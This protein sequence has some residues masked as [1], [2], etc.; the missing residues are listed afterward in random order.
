MLIL[1]QIAAALCGFISA[2]FWWRS[3]LIKLTPSL[4]LPGGHVG[5]GN[6][7]V[8]LANGNTLFWDI[9]MQGRLNARAAVFTALSILLQV[10]T[11]VMQM[12]F[13]R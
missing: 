9:D 8:V 3:S 13:G 1:T 6:L 2:Y 7:G 12:H 5:D 10:A 11:I 4:G